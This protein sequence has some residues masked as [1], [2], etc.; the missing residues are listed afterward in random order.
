MM[1]AILWIF[2]AIG[3]AAVLAVLGAAV[4]SYRGRPTVGV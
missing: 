2:A 4:A 1:T 3:L